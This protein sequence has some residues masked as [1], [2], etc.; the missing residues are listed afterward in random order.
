LR[1]GWLAS[2]LAAFAMAVLLAPG[3][4]FASGSGRVLA[5]VGNHR[6][7]EK[8]VDAKIKPQMA[9][10]QNRIYELKK[11]AIDELADQYLLEQAAKKDHLSVPEYLKRHLGTKSVTEAEAKKFYK[12]HK[13]IA[14]HYPDF[15]KI[16]GR[17]IQALDNQRKTE[18]RDALIERLRK[19]EPVKVMLAPPRLKVKFAGSPQLGPAT[20]PV[21]IVE[22]G[23]FQCPFCKRAEPTLTEV[24]KKY[25]K[26]V[27]LVYMDFPLPFHQH[28][29][30]AAEGARCAKEQGK[31]W[32]FHDHLF[33]NQE[34]LSKSDLKE[35]AK[36]LGL[37]TKRFDAC[38]DKG[39]YRSAIE[40]DVAEGHK[41]GVSGTPAFFINGR[42][43][44]GAQPFAQFAQVIDDELGRSVKTQHGSRQRQAS[45]K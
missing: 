20:A 36:K 44:S 23:D 45:A 6:I 33:E 27:R 21:T 37:N 8:D 32:P 40:A 3:S 4:A 42:P 10:L 34:K 24:L 7:T 16:K 41:L 9:A 19:D 38:L 30:E 13:Q 12:D 25:G 35:T 28:A 15:D 1:Y 29:M 26:K 18:Q 2:I 5:T 14:Q 17:L 11:G 39:K 43:L 22:F 31:F